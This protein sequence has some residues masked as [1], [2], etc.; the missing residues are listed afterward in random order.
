MNRPQQLYR[1]LIFDFFCQTISIT[2]APLYGQA[3][4]ADNLPLY[5]RK[6]CVFFRNQ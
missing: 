5:L 4:I 1:L 2:G 6:G 3:F